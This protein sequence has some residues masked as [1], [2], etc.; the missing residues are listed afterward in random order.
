MQTTPSALWKY[1][2][3]MLY[4]LLLQI[5]YRVLGKCSTTELHLKLNSLEQNKL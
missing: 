1:L 5:E 2:N 3:I 4:L